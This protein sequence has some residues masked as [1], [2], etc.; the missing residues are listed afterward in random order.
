MNSVHK[1][2][3]PVT[4]LQVVDHTLYYTDGPSLSR[5][6]KLSGSSLFCTIECTA[7]IR[8]IRKAT[9]GLLCAA[10]KFLFECSLNGSKRIDY[11]PS[12][13][14]ADMWVSESKILLA[15]AHGDVIILNSD[16]SIFKRL[17][18][19]EYA[20]FYSAHFLND[21][22][23]A[24]G[25]IFNGLWIYEI[26]E[27]GLNFVKD[28][29]E[30]HRGSIYSITSNS[31]YILS[32][33]DD[34][35]IGVW[36]KNDYRFRHAFR[37]HDARIWSIHCNE[38]YLV[39]GSEDGTVRSW[40]LSELANTH[41]IL[42]S[43]QG[44]N[45]WSVL[46]AYDGTV[47]SGGG[48]G[49]VL[50]SS[51]D[52]SKEIETEYDVKVFHQL[53]DSSLFYMNSNNVI[54]KGAE[55]YYQND[56]LKKFCV[57]SS[58]DDVLVIGDLTGRVHLINRLDGHVSI[59]QLS[60]CKIM[61]VHIFKQS[62]LAQ[63]AKLNVFVILFDKD[64]QVSMK[65]SNNFDKL[66]TSTYQLED[67]VFL[68][69]T[70]CGRI[71]KVN[72]A[73][74]LIWE[75]LLTSDTIT[76]VVSYSQNMVQFCTRSG[77]LGFIDSSSG[78]LLSIE[79]KCS[80]A[81]EGFQE[82]LVYGFYNKQFVV[83]DRCSKQTLFKYN[84]G[85]G[86]RLWQICDNQFI[87][88][89]DSCLRKVSLTENQLS[90]VKPGLNGLETRT[91]VSFK[92]YLLLGGEDCSLILA[93]CDDLHPLYRIQ[94]DSAIK[95]ISKLSD[96]GIFAVVG[97]KELTSIVKILDDGIILVKSF[98]TS[99]EDNIRHLCV[100][101]DNHH[102]YVGCSDGSIKKY[103][104]DFAFLDTI[105]ICGNCIMSCAI[106][107]G[108]LYAGTSN[109]RIVIIS[110]ST[111]QV[112]K[113]IDNA[114]GGAIMCMTV[115]DNAVICG[116]DDG[117]ISFVVMHEVVRKWQ[118]HN[119]TITSL[120]VHSNTL[121]S[122]SVDQRLCTHENYMQNNDTLL[123]SPFTT[124]TLIPLTDASSMCTTF[125][126]Q[127]VVAGRGLISLAAGCDGVPTCSEQIKRPR[128]L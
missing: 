75:T 71:L 30:H 106:L 42:H 53:S 37:G 113:L 20:L 121:Y 26:T 70:R 39:S 54:M 7:T 97:A 110:L 46:I 11:G 79:P 6:D 100:T 16:Y 125:G 25:T 90:C 82:N 95:S 23:I 41:F 67:K 73:I 109:G 108:E 83:S 52:T 80:T 85:G 34:R 3:L 115:H 123:P 128:V 21:R 88:L 51:V 81:Y 40:S 17:F 114:H 48:D 64:L 117:Y 61:K 43:H 65:A 124:S 120:L 96:D 62:L 104:L 112:I 76:G 86:H 89:R 10:G 60:E 77:Q 93:N 13:W 58:N 87:Y 38:H 44:K 69:G 47:F 35:T 19:N 78:A 74:D 107:D 27:E 8:I 66:I 68:L 49:A 102:L 91:V 1:S 24:F 32:A 45:V 59:L 118:A 116:G 126:N 127:L 36:D 98:S 122:V 56:Q 99:T 15:T 92:N 29:S 55:Q 103:S 28:L 4:A 119:S 22:M 63:D 101:T 18:L 9:N 12:D 72:C 111:N 31:H 105:H 14:I 33:S 57:F 94:Y 84:C 2:C 50:S 5:Y